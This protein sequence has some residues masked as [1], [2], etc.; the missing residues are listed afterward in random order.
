MRLDVA[1]D[2]DKSAIEAQAKHL[3][4]TQLKILEARYEE[5]YEHLESMRQIVAAERIEKATL[6]SV[7]ETM[8]HPNNIG[9][10]HIRMLLHTHPHKHLHKL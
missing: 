10:T 7:L 6:M 3:Y 5:Q 4:E 8:A 2:A 1:L 9:D